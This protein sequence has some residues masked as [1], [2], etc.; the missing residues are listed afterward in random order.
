MA[1]MLITGG[2]GM[3]GSY[4]AQAFKEHEVLCTDLRAP[5]HFEAAAFIDGRISERRYSDSALSQDR[6]GASPRSFSL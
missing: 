6:W 2:K 1:R 5:G 4:A 3:V